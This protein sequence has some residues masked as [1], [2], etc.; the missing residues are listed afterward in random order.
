[1]SS[2]R[3][4]HRVEHRAELERDPIERLSYIPTLLAFKLGRSPHLLLLD[5][6]ETNGD[7]AAIM[8]VPGALPKNAPPKTRAEEVL[9]RRAEQAKTEPIR[10]AQQAPTNT[11]KEPTRRAAQPP[12][13]PKKP[14]P[15]TMRPPKTPMKGPSTKPRQEPQQKPPTSEEEDLESEIRKAS[16]S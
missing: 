9:G 11:I 8:A 10:R 13:Q 7:W 2:P 1:M 5:T 4:S 16:C 14:Q 12:P 6:E 3:L 15:A